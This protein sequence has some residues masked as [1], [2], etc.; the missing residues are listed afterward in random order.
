MRAGVTN[1][2]AAAQQMIYQHLLPTLETT[3]S[4][5][6]VLPCLTNEYSVVVS[7]DDST[8][9]LSQSRRSMFPSRPMN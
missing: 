4:H 1:M 2:Q 9:T 3:T 5:T 6:R 7:Q 8:I